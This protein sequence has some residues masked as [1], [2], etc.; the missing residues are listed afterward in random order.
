MGGEKDPWTPV[1]GAKIYQE[2]A[3]SRPD[4]QFQ[5]IPN[6]G[7]CPHD[8]NPATVNAQILEWLSNLDHV[9]A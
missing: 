6:A 3:N 1:A 7:H 4:V 2:L 9:K 5:I 8:E